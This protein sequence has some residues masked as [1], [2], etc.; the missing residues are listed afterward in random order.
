ME[1]IRI[2]IADDQVLIAQSIK[3]VL[4]TQNP[5]L[6]VVGIAENG[7]AAVEIVR[8]EKPD[9]VLM[10]V[11]MPT[12]DGVE[13]TRIIKAE[14]GDAKVI[15]LST[16]DD[17]E[18]VIEALRCG[19]VGYLLKDISTDELISAIIAVYKGSVLISPSIAGKIVDHADAEESGS[20]LAARRGALP[21]Y[22]E[23]TAREKEIVHYIRKGYSN[24]EISQALNL[25]I[26]T[27]KNS[28]STIYE[29]AGTHDRKKV[30]GEV[31]KYHL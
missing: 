17:D 25:A 18:Y 22:D 5:D 29:K 13:A 3:I 14:H 8:R 15:M 28:V 2:V 19:A 23:L 31:E 26:Q 7:R 30:Q 4:E 16:F 12:L 20:F 9:I 27:V 6:S 21:W 11:R 24:K 10:D 1:R